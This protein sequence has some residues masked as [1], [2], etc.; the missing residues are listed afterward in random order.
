MKDVGNPLIDSSCCRQQIW[1]KKK[2]RK[3]CLYQ[4]RRSCK[5]Q[6]DPVPSPAVMMISLCDRKLSHSDFFVRTE[7]LSVCLFVAF[8][9]FFVRVCVPV[10]STSTSCQTI[11][12]SPKGVIEYIYGAYYEFKLDESNLFRQIYRIS[13][14]YKPRNRADGKSSEP[15]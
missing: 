4:H 9:S 11:R 12:K 1:Q 10:Y 15:E 13:R 6:I 2:N 7:L 8:V 5:L 14:I 3:I